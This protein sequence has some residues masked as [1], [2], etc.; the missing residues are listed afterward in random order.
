[1]RMDLGLGLGL[2]II[3]EVL[4]KCY[5]AEIVAYERTLVKLHR[6]LDLN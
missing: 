6:N 5:Y 4:E 3:Y 2:V 1:M